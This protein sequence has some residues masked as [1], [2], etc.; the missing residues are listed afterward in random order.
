[1]IRYIPSGYVSLARGFFETQ[2]FEITTQITISVSMVFSSP[3]KHNL[4]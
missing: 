3:E 4:A 2:A 1:M